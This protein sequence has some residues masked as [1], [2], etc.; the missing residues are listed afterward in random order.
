MMGITNMFGNI[1]GILTPVVAGKLTP[2]VS[3]V[4]V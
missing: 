3:N 4:V 1:P 2:H